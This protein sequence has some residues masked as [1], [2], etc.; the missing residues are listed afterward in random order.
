VPANHAFGP[1]D[2]ADYRTRQQRS[3]ERVHVRTQVVSMQRMATDNFYQRSSFGKLDGR[4]RRKPDLV[5]LEE[6]RRSRR[7]D[8][9]IADRSVVACPRD[10]AG[11]R[12]VAEFGIEVAAGGAARLDIDPGADDPR[13]VH[14]FLDDLR[15]RDI[16]AMVNYAFPLAGHI[17]GAG[18][19]EPSA[20]VRPFPSV[21]IPQPPAACAVAVL[22]TGISAEVRTDGYLAMAVAGGDV[23]ELDEFPP[24]GLLDAGAGHGS[25]VTG[26]IQQVAPT[27]QI[28]IHKVVDS[29]GITTDT[30]L[31]DG[32]R[33]AAEHGAK[34][35][36]MSLGTET[37]DDSAPPALRAAVRELQDAGVLLVCA[38]G[39]NAE[40]DPVWPAA[41]SREFE[42]VVAVAALDPDGEPAPWSSH[43]DWVT[44]SAIGEGVVS[45]YV[46]GT[47]DGVLIDDPD[48]DTY[49]P[50]SWACWTGTSF[51]TPQITG[52]LVRLMAED[53]GLR[54][55]L[56]ALR[57]LEKRSSGTR[58]GY[59]FTVRI[60]PGT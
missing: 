54:T 6:L 52:A 38:A 46:I 60:L 23:D 10:D 35:I 13:T 25:F 24:F 53:T 40:D 42:N 37:E 58:D 48:P 32:L 55:P 8:L 36:N 14:A 22:D 49:G 57:E 31:A 45:T 30:A 18:G 39:N 4:R 56:D 28:T 29:D 9:M 19:P 11:R 5:Q 2:Y 1:A 43:G 47:E 3:A 44:C 34:I 7:P 50:D 21:R 15:N 20:C 51:S 27:A 26:I 33:Y 41:L 59:G 12:R 17:K 16:H